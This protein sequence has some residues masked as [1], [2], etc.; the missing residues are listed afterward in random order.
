MAA[1]AVVF[2]RLSPERPHGVWLEA[3]ETL[4]ASST[5]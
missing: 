4:P 3:D 1:F 2:R 5:M